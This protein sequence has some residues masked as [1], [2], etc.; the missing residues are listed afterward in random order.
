[1]LAR[2]FGWNAY[3]ESV[4]NNPYLADFYKDMKRWSF[5]LQV[6]FLSHRFRIHRKIITSEESVVQ[7]R[8]IYE[9]VEIFAGNLYHMGRMEK[10]DYMNYRHLFREMTSF[11]VPPD[12]IVYLKAGV[13]TLL[14]Q[15]NLRGRDF[16][17]NIERKYLERLNIS[18]G[19][20]VRK[21]N[22][23]RL[24]V[25]ESDKLDFVNRKSDFLLIRDKIIKELN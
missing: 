5:H 14:N 23:G 3:Y 18:Y 9:D 8:S 1:M 10:R 24:I 15:I 11:L 16:E 13:K 2:E 21:Y 12:L 19:R 20:W 4:V 6:Y 17:K 22:L 7:D 25:I